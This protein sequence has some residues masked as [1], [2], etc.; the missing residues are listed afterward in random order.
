MPLL[1]IR[2]S[3]RRRP[4]QGAWWAETAKYYDGDA[5][6]TETS[7]VEEFLGGG[8]N[9]AGFVQVMKS[10]D[11][12]RDAMVRMDQMFEKHAGLRPELIGLIRLWTG[13]DS[14]IEAAYFT[15]EAAARSGEQVEMPAELQA[16]MA[17]SSDWMQNTEFLDLTDP[18]LF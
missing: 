13:P 7:D 14:C 2:G 15:T 16:A 4:E 10:H 5:V 1:L 18:L 17:E 3:L 6:F 8:S 12:D 11:V 9:D